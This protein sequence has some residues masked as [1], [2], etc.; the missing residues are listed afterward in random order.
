MTGHHHFCSSSCV[1]GLALPLPP[2]SLPAQS[3][4]QW[5]V[6]QN[7]PSIGRGGAEGQR[8]VGVQALQILNNNKR[9]LQLLP[10]KR[11]DDIAQWLQDVGVHIPEWSATGIFAGFRR[12]ASDD[13]QR[14]RKRQAVRARSAGPRSSQSGGSKKRCKQRA[15]AF[16]CGDDS[17]VEVPTFVFGQRGQ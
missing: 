5:L 11:I 6:G 12:F 3:G 1:V 13:N 17:T 14:S 4:S 9:N 16:R 10:S 7:V 2:P 8:S 15:F